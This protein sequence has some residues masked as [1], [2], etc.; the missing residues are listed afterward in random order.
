MATRTK[1]VPTEEPEGAVGAAAGAGLAG[2]VS[3]TTGMS[4]AKGE[5]SSS[6]KGLRP[7]RPGGARCHARPAIDVREGALER[8]S[9]YGQFAAR[10]S[11]WKNGPRTSR[12]QRSVQARNQPGP[13]QCRRPAEKCRG[14]AQPESPAAGRELRGRGIYLF[15]QK[16]ND[17]RKDT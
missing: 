5:L 12:G 7:F 13:A 6:F 16:E 14:Q 11:R 8:V 1:R 3:A 9:R 17:G 2:A 15:E 10:P 4:N